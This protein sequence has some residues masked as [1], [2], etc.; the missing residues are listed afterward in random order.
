LFE[1]HLNYAWVDRREDG[2]IQILSKSIS[3]PFF[4]TGNTYA[5]KTIIHK[6]DINRLEAHYAG[7]ENGINKT[8]FTVYIKGE[9]NLKFVCSSK[10]QPNGRILS[11]WILF[12]DENKSLGLLAMAAHD[13]RSPI[14]SIVGLINLMQMMMG[15]GQVPAEELSNMMDMIKTSSSKAL[16]LTDEILELADMESDRYVLT[17]KPMMMSE[18]VENY[19]KTHAAFKLKKRIEIVLTASTV[20]VCDINEARLTRVFDN[21]I[22]NASKFSYPDSTI[23]IIIDDDP[24]GLVVKIQDHGVGMPK[25]MIDE[26]FVKFGKAQRPGL[27]GE[28]SHGLGMS[29]VK[30]IMTLHGGYITV[31]SEERKGTTMNLFFKQI[32]GQA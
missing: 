7:I 16:L 14:S 31:E 8:Q 12:P 6:L 19:I 26:I 22:S 32:G 30:Q 5:L 10:R 4:E 24:Y 27:E 18:Y 15:D 21:L 2:E 29:I 17:T 13:M 3:L 25:E 20:G 11:L 23:D 28:D 1:S 9:D